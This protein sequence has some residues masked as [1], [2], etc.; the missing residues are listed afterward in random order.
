MLRFQSGSL[1][2]L[3]GVLFTGVLFTGVA[4]A[5]ALVVTRA[6][7]ASTIVEIFVERDAIRVELEIG[8]VDLP[9]F[10][11][12]LP[13]EAYE[14]LGYP[15]RPHAERLADFFRS[16]L[17]LRIGKGDPLVGTLSQFKT[18]RRAVRDEITGQPLS[19]SDVK[20]EPIVFVELRYLLDGLPDSLTLKPPLRGDAGLI[21][22]NIGMV[23]Y[24]LGLPVN[25]FRYLGGAETLV[26]DWED[27]WYSRF[28]NRN[29][30][31]RYD[32]PMAAFL[33]VEPFEVRQEIILRPKDVQHWLDLGLDGK[34]LLKVNEQEAVK[35]KIAAFLADKNR[36]V[37]DGHS[38][39]G[40]LDRIRFIRRSLRRTGVIQ[41]PEDLSLDSAT[42]GIIFVYPTETLAQKVTMTWELFSPKIDKVPS[43]ATDEAGG[44]PQQ[45]TPFAPT[46]V[47]NNVLTNPTIPAMVSVAAPPPSP[48]I[49]VSIAQVICWGLAV[50]LGMLA[51]GSRLIRRGQVSWYLAIIGAGFLLSSLLVGGVARVSVRHPL[52]ET[53]LVSDE[54]M[55]P[56]LAGLLENVYRA[57]DRREE[58]LVYDRLARSISGE[59]LEEVYLQIHRSIEI[60]GQGGARV[61]LQQINLLL[62]ERQETSDAEA[63]VYRCKWRAAGSVGHWGHTHRRANEY[64]ALITLR[65]VDNVWKIT[66]LEL[67]EE[68]RVQLSAVASSET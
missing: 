55:K 29:L 45:L 57:F 64:E 9:A 25:D 47:W 44:V 11:N 8:V 65:G 7:T 31:R 2:I 42:L 61:R 3:L 39:S 52:R 60:A 33:Y 28:H 6:M 58:G 56:V 59:L 38:A 51:L 66:A 16:G 54:Q 23:V 27:P 14:R 46:L 17:T 50:L 10:R 21:A 36:V 34:S 53:P 32:A 49:E 18:G 48:T 1:S 41:P 22:A 35:Q 13:D 15:P 24:H 40:V 26:L 68:R 19:G 37:I 12:V 63:L 43:V 30:R 20:G 62:A 67:T 4:G 5:D